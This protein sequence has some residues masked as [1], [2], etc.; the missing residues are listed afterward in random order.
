MRV[1]NI[2]RY[3][4]RLGIRWKVLDI[5]ELRRCHHRVLILKHARPYG[6]Q[7]VGCSEHYPNIDRV[8]QST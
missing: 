2:D 8:A 5:D 3:I 1:R 6:V 4:C 7:I